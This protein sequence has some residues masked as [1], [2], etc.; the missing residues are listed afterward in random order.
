MQTGPQTNP[1]V[2]A[3]TGIRD[4]LRFRNPDILAQSMYATNP[5]F[6]S[7]VDSM[8]GKTPEQAFQENGYDFNMI[9]SI[10]GM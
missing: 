1:V 2:A 6:R 9:R 10:M 4:M 5:Q 3:V 7:F 8:R